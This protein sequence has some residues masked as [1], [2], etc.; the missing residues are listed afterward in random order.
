MSANLVSSLV[1]RIE[2]KIAVGEYHA[3]FRL[4]QEFLAKEFKVS[5][6]PI[7]EALQQLEARG[8]VAHHPGQGA[9]VRIPRPHEIREAYQIRAELEGL[10]AE[11]AMDWISAD[12]IEKMRDAQSRYKAAI[13]NYE[14]NG[15]DYGSKTSNSELE[16]RRYWIQA[17]DDFHRVILD[18]CPNQRLSN[19]VQDLHRRFT[20]SVM[21]S[22]SDI[23]SGKMRENIAQHDALL[24]AID[25]HDATEARRVLTHHILRAGEIFAKW[26]ELKD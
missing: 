23:G 3:G 25:R 21:I 20:R 24:N 7:R 2:N 6:T 13:E 14:V 26:V 1:T 22:S 19:L 9:I 15:F 17:N 18:A 10:A 12:G 8:L 16:G 4:K 11:L 5:R